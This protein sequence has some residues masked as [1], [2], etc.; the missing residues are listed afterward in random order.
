MKKIL[1]TLAKI[2]VSAVIIGL[3]FWYATRT[4]ESRDALEAIWNQPKQW[5]LLVAAWF[6]MTF[7]VVLTMVRWCYLV[8]ALGVALTMRD[9]LRIGFLGYLFNFLPMGIVGG[10]VLKA[11]MLAREYPGNRA[12]AVASVVVDRVIGLYILFVVAAAAVLMTGYWYSPTTDS[13]VVNICWIALAAAAVGTI[14]VVIVML[15]GVDEVTVPV[16]PTQPWPA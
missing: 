4:K 7:G 8:R 5:D 15:P 3:L 6:V 14:G 12:K 2:A 9:A 1:I 10:D 16:S 13:R 11:V